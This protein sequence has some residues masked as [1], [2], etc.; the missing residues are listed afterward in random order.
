MLR[1]R[2]FFYKSFYEICNFA[3]SYSFKKYGKGSNQQFSYAKVEVCSFYTFQ[4]NKN[5]RG[6]T[7]FA[8]ERKKI[9]SLQKK[10]SCILYGLIFYA[11]CDDVNRFSVSFFVFEKMGLRRFPVENC[12]PPTARVRIGKTQGPLPPKYEF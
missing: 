3:Y 4:E 10:I 5:L 2:T 8:S 7:F 6:V 1:V 11:V 12:W 9:F